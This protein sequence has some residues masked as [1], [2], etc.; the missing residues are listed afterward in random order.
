MFN[1]LEVQHVIRNQN[2]KADV[3]ASLAASM[4]LN[5]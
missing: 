4:A 1:I 2:E 5:P 3:L